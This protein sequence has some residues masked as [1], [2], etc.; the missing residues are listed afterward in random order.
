MVIQCHFEQKSYPTYVDDNLSSFWTYFTQNIALTKQ[1]CIV[2]DEQVDKIQNRDYPDQQKS[3][4]AI[5]EEKDLCYETIVHQRGETAKSLTSYTDLLTKI[6]CSNF[7]IDRQTPII[8]LGGGVT[9]DLAG[10]IA[11]TLLRGLPF[12]QIPTTLLAM[13][14][15]SVG[16]KVAINS[17]VGKNRIGSFYPPKIVYIS[18]HFLYTLE[19]KEWRCGIGEILKYALLIGPSYWQLCFQLIETSSKNTYISEQ[20]TSIWKE[21]IHQSIL[22]K[23]TIVRRDPFEQNIRK[24]LNLG[25][26]IG[27]VLERTL[28]DKAHQT[29]QTNYRLEPNDI[30]THGEC[31]CFGICWELRFMIE[32]GCCDPEILHQFRNLAEQFHMPTD[33]SH[34]EW[35]QLC[36]A[37]LHTIHWDKKKTHQNK[38]RI[39]SGSS[40]SLE[41]AI[42]EKNKSQHTSQNISIC[43]IEEI[44]QFSIQH[45]NLADFILFFQRRMT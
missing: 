29:S 42:I 36:K 10:F 16:A 24:S 28:L 21:I 8:A 27:H 18:M 44:G 25:H 17:M 37:N 2:I 14:D 3:L 32:Q 39:S 1:V 15:S 6:E 13:V 40:T 5:F 41:C 4:F 30:P 34:S 7:S 26:T 38:E 45:I 33:I 43:C 9:G 35:N 19:D 12:I 11:A 22:Y 20:N 31:V 23:N